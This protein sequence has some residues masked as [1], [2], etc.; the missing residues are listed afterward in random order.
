M[1]FE[2]TWTD[3]EISILSKISQTQR[4]KYHDIT[5]MS[6]LHFLNDINELKNR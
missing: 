2:A 4:N 3:L 1:P 6:N 5:N